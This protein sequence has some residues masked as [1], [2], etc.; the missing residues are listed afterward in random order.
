MTVKPR[1]LQPQP[2][3]RLYEQLVE[4]LLDY[5]TSAGL[6]AGDRLPAERELA[7]KLQVSRASVS[8]ALVSLEVQGIIDV[9]HGDGAVILEVPQSRQVLSA[10]GARRRRLRDVI[11]AREA[12]EVKLASLAAMRRDAKDLEAIEAAI[13]FMKQE[14]AEGDRGMGGD[15]AFHAAVTAAAHSCLLG[16]LMAEISELVRETRFESLS[17][18]GRPQESLRGHVAVAK[19][20]RAQDSEAAARA[21]AHHVSSVSDVGLLRD[22]D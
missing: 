19:A 14:I 7:S 1:G 3:S 13:A 10:L 2:R 12:M 15:E 20:I 17:Q 16:D 9:R 21:M 11:E 4:Q 5:M 8:Q 22:P 18:P 6:A